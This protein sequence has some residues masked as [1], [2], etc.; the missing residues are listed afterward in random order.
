MGHYNSY[1]SAADDAFFGSLEDDGA[2]LQERGPV[3]TRAA[4]HTDI[5]YG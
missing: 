4:K 2:Q 1:V 5:A 3:L